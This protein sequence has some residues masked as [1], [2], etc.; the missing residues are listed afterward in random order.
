MRRV[1]PE[2]SRLYPFVGLPGQQPF[3]IS[4]AAGVFFYPGGCDPARDVIVLGPAFVIGEAEIDL[5]V[6]VL[7]ASITSAVSRAET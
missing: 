5:L 3:A 4:R 6:E 2:R 1:D 7:E